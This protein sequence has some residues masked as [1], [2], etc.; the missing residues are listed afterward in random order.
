MKSYVGMIASSLCL[1]QT[2]LTKLPACV[3]DF[4]QNA[5]RISPLVHSR[6][7]AVGIRG[8]SYSSSAT[9]Q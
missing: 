9:P 5:K 8:A 3:D 2:A 7:L 4:R 1:N 6:F